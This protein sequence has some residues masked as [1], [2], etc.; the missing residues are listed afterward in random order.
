MLLILG[1]KKVKN[2]FVSNKL[3]LNAKKTK[4]MVFHKQ[5]K[6]VMDL[7]IS[8]N[9]VAISKVTTFNFLGLH[10][11]SNLTWNT[12]VQEISKK[13]SRVIGL[14]YKMQLIL[15]RRILLSLYN[16]MILPHINYCLLSWGKDNDSIL[17]LQKKA[18][19]VISSSEYR[20]HTEPLFKNLNILRISDIYNYKLLIFYYNLTNNNTPTYFDN[21]TPILSQGNNRYAF[22]RPQ[23]QIPKYY[24]VYSKLTC[25]YQLPHILNQYMTTDLHDNGE[26]APYLSFVLKNIQNVSL[27]SFKKSVKSYFVNKYSSE[28]TIA[29]CYI[30]QLYSVSSI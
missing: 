22:R 9:N 17:K 13:I 11:N 29:N 28:C 19:R 15:P 12:H 5:N 10:L 16:T 27:I 3:S 30:C 20:A 18:V 25:R 26:D 21:F 6:T 1:W 2:W 8:I 24:H 4:Y 7:N 14:L 23:F